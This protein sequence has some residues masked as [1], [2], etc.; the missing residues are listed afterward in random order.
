[1]SRRRVDAPAFLLAAV[2]LLVP[3][4]LAAARRRGRR[5]RAGGQRSQLLAV[6]T[7]LGEQIDEVVLARSTP[8]VQR[9]LDDRVSSR[10]AA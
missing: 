5:R 4:L 6:A 8:D 3:V 7:Q 2:V 9:G 10:L 1:M